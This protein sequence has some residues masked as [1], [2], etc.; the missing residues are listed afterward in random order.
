ME[1]CLSI[2]TWLWLRGGRNRAVVRAAFADLLPEEVILRRT[3]GR[4]ESMCAR[5]YEA[6]RETIASLLLDGEMKRR[7]LLDLLR[8]EPYLRA[9]GPPRDDDYFRIFDLVS[10]ELW[11]RS[12]GR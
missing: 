4:L 2:P 5:A 3:K 11:L 9:E 7:G 1:L 10:L 6:N 8:L 12:V